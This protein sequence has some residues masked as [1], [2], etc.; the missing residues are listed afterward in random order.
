MNSNIYHT[1]SGG[2]SEEI[3]SSVDESLHSIA[4]HLLEIQQGLLQAKKNNTIKDE[5]ELHRY[6]YRLDEL[7]SDYKDNLVW[8]NKASNTKQTIPK[9]QA[10]L[11]EL[12]DDCHDII[13]S[14]IDNLNNPKI[15][16]RS[17]LKSSANKSSSEDIDDSLISIRNHLN[18]VKM[19]LLKAKDLSSI[20]DA[21]E[22]RK[23]Q[24]KLNDLE[25]QY[26]QGLI[27]KTAKT[28][29]QTLSFYDCNA[30]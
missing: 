5:L 19:H 17:T 29:V 2:L 13:N 24:T 22:L 14:I 23:F 4:Q 1:S 8:R 7:E 9:G 18:S 30:L 21:G 15:N 12:L 16:K 6:Q 10:L 3:L 27:W 25:M 26:K 11:N 20:K 28:Q